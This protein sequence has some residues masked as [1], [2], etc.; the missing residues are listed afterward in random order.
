MAPHGQARGIINA[1]GWEA[2]MLKRVVW[3]TVSML[4]C[5]DCSTLCEVRLV[6]LTTDRRMVYITA[7][8]FCAD[9]SSI[10]CFKDVPGRVYNEAALLGLP[11]V[12]YVSAG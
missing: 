9:H 12:G 5:P 7:C 4:Q 11:V 3:D 6:L 8:A 1:S 2:I 10:R